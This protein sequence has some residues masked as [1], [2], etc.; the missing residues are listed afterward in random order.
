MHIWIRPHLVKGLRNIL[1]KKLIKIYYFSGTGNTL[2][3][4]RKI[5]DVFQEKGYEVTL[6]KITISGCTELEDDCHLGIVVPV[7]MQSTFPI[8]WDFI[9]NLPEGEKR[10]VFL[11]DTM[12]LFSGGIVGPIKKCLE[13]KGYKCIGACEFK[14]ATSM[15]TSEKKA[16]SGKRKNKTALLKAEEY[17][18]SLIDGSSTWH[19]VPI[20]SD[21]M[22][23]ISKGRS[24]WT[25]MSERIKIDYSICVKCRVC[26]KHCP[27]NAIRLSNERI[28]IQHTNCIA[29]MRCVNYCPQN[30]F[31]LRGEHVIQKQTVKVSEL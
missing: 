23:N 9:D 1:S 28:E 30:A 12:E 22:R 27:A 11:A 19:R 15:Q 20:L 16:A 5:K 3:I 18:Q 24:I 29:C 8:V 6:R 26:E 7:A 2:L 10:Q 31:K 13:A 17:V 4:A 25:K 14:M 21:A